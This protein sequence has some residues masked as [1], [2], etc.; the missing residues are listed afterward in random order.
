MSV[1]LC[2]G[3]SGEQSAARSS[4]VRQNRSQ[5]GHDAGDT[6]KVTRQ[7]EGS[8]T[9]RSVRCSAGHVQ[10]KYSVYGAE[11]SLVLCLDTLHGR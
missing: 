8:G 11:G 2:D 10:V 5:S 1:C 9:V 6:G 4:I 7:A 3:R